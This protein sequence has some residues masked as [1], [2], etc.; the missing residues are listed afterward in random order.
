MKRNQLIKTGLSLFLFGAFM[1]ALTYVVGVYSPAGVALAN[2]PILLDKTGLT[3]ENLKLIE[4]IEKRFVKLDVLDQKGITEAIRSALEPYLKLKDLSIEKVAELM[5]EKSGVRAILVK[6]GE[7]ITAMKGSITNKDNGDWSIRGQVAAW[8]EKNK[9]IIAAVRNGQSK[10]IP[11][12][13]LDAKRA[14]A[15]PM[16]SA[17]S[18]TGG[19]SFA[20][21]PVPQFE[22]GIHDI[23]RIQPT[24]WD[25]L[26]KGRTSSAAYTWVN[27]Q[28]AQGGA[29]FIGQG[30]LK[31][32]S[33]FELVPEISNA[34]KIAVS[35]K[36]STELLDDIDGMTSY[37]TNELSYLLKSKVN[38]TLMTGTLST[39]VPAGIQT[40]SVAFSQTGLATAN[41]TVQDC[42][43]AAVTQLRMR[44]ITEPITVFI[45][46]VDSANMDM[47]KASTAGTYILPP[48]ATADGKTIAGATIVEDN[49]VAVGFMQVAALSLFK[50][51]IYKDF[52]ITWGWENDDF[53]KNLVTVLAEM[54]L[55]SFH[56]NNDAQAFIYDSFANVKA[57]ITG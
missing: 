33:S 39:T 8:Q 49:N 53:T 10:A 28:N 5:D 55:H 40:V 14:V 56:S 29:G 1:L 47:Q 30:V 17:N 16:T 7:E 27:K 19:A 9:E 48:F 38:T 42:I 4:D 15:S 3:G 54:R 36:V 34:K 18:L 37:I 22:G 43:R 11:E 21:L 44:Y 6:Q 50:V 57:L 20:L 52:A 13:V 45:S 25:Y 31:P 2:V 41:P 51:L 46:P 24:F 32:N 12:F 26:V 35:E 23:R